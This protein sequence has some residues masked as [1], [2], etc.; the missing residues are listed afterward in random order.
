M[1][2]AKDIGAW[3]WLLDS[4][5]NVFKRQGASGQLMPWVAPSWMN[6]EEEMRRL[7]GSK[8]EVVEVVLEPAEEII[9]KEDI[10]KTDVKVVSGG[11]GVKKVSDGDIEEGVKRVADGVSVSRVC[12]DLGIS[13]V[14][15]YKRVEGYEKRNPEAF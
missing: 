8:E 9:S 7:Y 5:G 11:R 10:P 4:K 3:Q 6:V 15:W 12:R 13:R 1:K 14:T 2:I